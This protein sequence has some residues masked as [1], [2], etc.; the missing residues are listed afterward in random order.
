MARVA[1][2]VVLMAAIAAA[3]V[4]AAD[5]AA[6]PERSEPTPMHQMIYKGVVGNVLEVLPLESE[7]RVQL[8]RG[9][10]VVSNTMTGRSL[11]LL[12]GL[13]SPLLTVGGFVWGLWSAANI[14]SPA[15]V[16]GAPVSD[17]VLVRSTLRSISDTSH[18]AMEDAL[19]ALI[20]IGG[21]E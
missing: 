17:G 21:G 16:P 3:P 9:N 8:Q 4:R 5:N 7:D 19:R 13:A 14:K 12:L 6:A 18:D 2:I 20:V 1:L 11:N 15:G 10:S